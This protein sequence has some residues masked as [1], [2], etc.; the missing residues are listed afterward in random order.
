MTKE[1]RIIFGLSDLK[2]FR[3]V[4]RNCKG[5]TTYPVSAKKS[6]LTD[7]CPHCKTQFSLG[8]DKGVID[9]LVEAMQSVLANDDS[10]KV[11]LEFEM[12]DQPS[13]EPEK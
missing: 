7:H 5:A 10:L 9:K 3:V 12:E 4:C 1:H 8:S 2:N 13:E 11:D 6:Y